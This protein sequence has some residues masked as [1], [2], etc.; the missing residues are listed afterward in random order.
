MKYKNVKKLI[1]CFWL[2]IVVLEFIFVVIP[3]LIFLRNLSVCDFIDF[4][5]R[6]IF[7]CS[8]LLKIVAIRNQPPPI[9]RLPGDFSEKVIIFSLLM[10][11]GRHS[12]NHLFK[13]L[14]TWCWTRT[15]T[16]IQTRILCP[17]K[18]RHNGRH[19]P[20]T[21]SNGWENSYKVWETVRFPYIPYYN[22]NKV[23]KLSLI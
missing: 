9:S 10:M 17:T 23:V 3:P 11:S 6:R 16:Q 4:P 14:K 1:C 8:A 13:T 2:L 5:Y 7:I 22:D 19:S 20:G 18:Y 12:I 21:N 15:P